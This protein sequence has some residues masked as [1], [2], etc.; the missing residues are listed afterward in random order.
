[1]AAKAGI[2]RL[3]IDLIGNEENL[4]GGQLLAQPSEQP[5]RTF[6]SALPLRGHVR[7]ESMLPVVVQL[8]RIPGVA[9]TAPH[10]G[11][12]RSYSNPI[13]GLILRGRG[14]S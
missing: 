14:G 11:A 8:Q 4:R 10:A 5:R 2:D 1:M 12:T 9:Y 3:G 7:P 6:V 13:P